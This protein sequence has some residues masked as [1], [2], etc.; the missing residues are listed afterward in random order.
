MLHNDKMV[1]HAVSVKKIF[2]PKL[3]IKSIAIIF[4]RKIRVGT[5]KIVFLNLHY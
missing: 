3:Q 1:D 4:T 5:K 2:E